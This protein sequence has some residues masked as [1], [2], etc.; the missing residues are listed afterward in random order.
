[1]Y[2]LDSEEADGDAYIGHDGA[3]LDGEDGIGL[4]GA[5]V[6]EEMEDM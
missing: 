2:V 3:A 4:V 1:M 5:G 6:T